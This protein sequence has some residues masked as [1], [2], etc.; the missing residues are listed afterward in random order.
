[1][2]QDDAIPCNTMQYHAIPCNTMHYHAIPC[3]TMQ[4]HA[5]PCNTMQ[6]HALLCNTMHYHAIPCNTLRYHAI[7]CNTMQYHVSLITADRAYHCP[8]GSIMAIFSSVRS[9]Y[10]HPDLLVTQQH[11]P[12]FP[13]HTGPQHWT[14]TFYHYS[15]IKAIMLYKGNHWTPCAGFMD[16]SGVRLNINNDDLRSSW[17]LHE[18]NLGMIWG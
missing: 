5:M 6:Y 16:A 9:S 14:F 7:Q 10:S 4:Y 18:D 13:D 1:M 3:N 2:V 12:T 17:K 15:Y 8:V 11:H